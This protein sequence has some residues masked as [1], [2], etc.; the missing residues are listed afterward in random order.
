LPAIFWTK[1]FFLVL[2]VFPLEEHTVAFPCRTWMTI[3]QG[4]SDERSSLRTILS[5]TK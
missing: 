2:G 1:R 5:S 3:Q 4:G